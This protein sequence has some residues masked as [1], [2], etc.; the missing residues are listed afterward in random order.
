MCIYI[1]IYIHIHIHIH[2]Y[3]TMYYIVLYY[4]ML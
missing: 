3:T 2:E 4:V 1:Y